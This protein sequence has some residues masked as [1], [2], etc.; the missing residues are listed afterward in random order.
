[1]TSNTCHKKSKEGC[2]VPSILLWKG[3]HLWGNDGIEGG[4]NSWP[5]RAASFP[6]LT[7]TVISPV[8]AFQCQVWFNAFLEKHV[9]MHLFL[10]KPSKEI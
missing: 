10:V 1:M 4:K 6:S 5:R 7:T 3:I 8:K 9:C 2:H